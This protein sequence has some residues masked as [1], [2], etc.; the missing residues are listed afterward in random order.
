MCKHILCL[1]LSI[2]EITPSCL[3]FQVSQVHNHQIAVLYCFFSLET[4]ITEKD[5]V[6]QKGKLIFYCL[7]KW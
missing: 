4:E 1:I 7:R 6:Q 5:A 3:D 2:A